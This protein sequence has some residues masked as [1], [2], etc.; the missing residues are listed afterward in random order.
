M[1]E[2]GFLTQAQRDLITLF[3]GLVAVVTLWQLLQIRKLIARTIT[4]AKMQNVPEYWPMAAMLTFL[5]GTLVFIIISIFHLVEAK[6]SATGP[7]HAPI[8]VGGLAG[9][10]IG[11]G[12]GDLAL[13]VSRGR[14]HPAIHATVIVTALATT[15]FFSIFA[16]PD[17]DFLGIAIPGNGIKAALALL[18]GICGYIWGSKLWR[19]HT[20]DQQE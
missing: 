15:Y 20:N 3:A 14:I 6:F 2:N 19:Y 1:L 11:I 10:I 13:T 8:V 16:W 17:S 7:S 12:L 18:P 4:T 5:A 9:L